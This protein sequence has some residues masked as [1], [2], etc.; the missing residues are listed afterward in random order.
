[1]WLSIQENNSHH[2]QYSREPQTHPLGAHLKTVGSEAGVPDSP[3]TLGHLRP[4]LAQEAWWDN[5]LPSMAW[6]GLPISTND[7]KG[8]K[9]THAHTNLPSLQ[10][11]KA[12]QLENTTITDL[13]GRE[14]ALRFFPRGLGSHR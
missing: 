8:H 5:N 7:R 6:E 14:A 13:P 4:D 10:K 12:R 11:R 1:M 3:E 2:T 9:H